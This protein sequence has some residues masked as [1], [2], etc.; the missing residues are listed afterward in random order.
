M[1]TI[2]NSDSVPLISPKTQG[3]WFQIIDVNFTQTIIGLLNIFALLFIAFSKEK[4]ED[5]FIRKV[6]LDAL[7]MATYV[8]Y[9][10]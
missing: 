1:I 6:R 10:F 9:G 5:E 3:H 7:V 8:N 2:Y 4:E